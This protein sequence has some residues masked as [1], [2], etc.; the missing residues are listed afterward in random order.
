[1][2]TIFSLSWGR[3]ACVS[4]WGVGRR[5]GAGNLAGEPGDIKAFVDRVVQWIPADVLAIYTLGITTL[6]IQKP[7]PNPTLAWLIIAGVLAPV[8]LLLAAWR[9]RKTLVKRDWVLAGMSI[10]AFAIWSLAVPESGWYRI[11]WITHN[12]GWVA[13]LAGAAGMLFGAVAD[14]F[15]GG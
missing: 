6:K 10:V 13:L 7:D 15:A 2:Y 14:T 1:M 8:I 3:G 11:D 4:A 5:S 12:P 9:T